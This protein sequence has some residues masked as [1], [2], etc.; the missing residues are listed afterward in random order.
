MKKTL[1]CFTLVLTLFAGIVAAQTQRDPKA[2]VV[3]QNVRRWAILVGVNDY[4]KFGDLKYCV[5]DVTGLRDELLKHGY[6]E[7]RIFCLT[8]RSHDGVNFQPTY[9]NIDRTVKQVLKQLQKGDQLL[10]VLSG[11]G[12]MI[13]GKSY[14]CPEDADDAQP[15]TTLLDIEQLYQI[16][17]QSK[18]T[19]KMLIVDA[20]RNRP[21]DSTV[22]IPDNVVQQT[23][24]DPLKGRKAAS[25]AKGI[26]K[27][28]PP[29][30]GIVLLTSCNEGEYSFEDSNLKHGVFTH[31][32]INAVQGKADM[33]NDGLI[34]L[35]ELSNYVCEETP[36]YT[37]KKFSAAQTPYLAGKTTAYYIAATQ[38]KPNVEHSTSSETAAAVATEKPEPEKQDAKPRGIAKDYTLNLS[39]VPLGSLPQGWEGPDNAVVN[40]IRGR[41]CVTNNTDR[42]PAELIVNN[43]FSQ[44]SDFS[45][46][47]TCF[48]G[49]MSSS[50]HLGKI[51][52]ENGNTISFQMTCYGYSLGDSPGKGARLKGDV[53]G[54]YTIKRR[55]NILSMTC[56]GFEDEVIT[57]RNSTFKTLTGF[58]ITLPNSRSGISQLSVRQINESNDKKN[59]G[60]DS[61]NDGNE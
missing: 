39:N 48:M 41:K 3:E 11:H 60:F 33:N 45:V 34:S 57:I 7:K 28:P 56:D 27:L 24:Q 42:T 5:S 22:E 44:P 4:V 49:A 40:N 1:I 55:D 35:L 46:H 61:G 43:L 25:G 2:L 18:A 32:L 51:T 17:E 16:V 12:L 9:A 26:E 47:F 54:G 20:C 15:K 30:A 36:L 14:Y 58:Q 29:P 23:S 10:I 19:N 53:S 37:M 31:F 59:N 13:S 38:I 50:R 8:T 6:E 21:S 52:D